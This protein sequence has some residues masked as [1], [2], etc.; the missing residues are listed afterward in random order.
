MYEHL[1]KQ[2]IAAEIGVHRGENA[3][4]LLRLTNPK[5]LILIDVWMGSEINPSYYDPFPREEHERIYQELLI[6]LKGKPAKVIRKKSLEA[7]A[8]FPDKHFN[9]VYLDAEHSYEAVSSELKAIEPKIVDNGI[10][11]G[12]DFCDTYEGLQ[13]AVHEFMDQHEWNMIALTEEKFASFAL[14]K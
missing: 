5:E 3:L 11:L 14:R 6:K 13:K 7:L 8:E 1:P 9:W 2:A 12:H 10:I 4:D